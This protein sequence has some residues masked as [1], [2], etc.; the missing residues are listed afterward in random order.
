M[1][2]IMHYQYIRITIAKS[3]TSDQVIVGADKTRDFY[4]MDTFDCERKK[5]I[6]HQSS[7]FQTTR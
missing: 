1:H 7:T 3:K 5:L 2:A 6:S 4:K